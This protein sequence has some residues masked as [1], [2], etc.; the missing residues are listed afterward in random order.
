MNKKIHVKTGDTVVVLEGRDRGKKGKVLAVS[1]KEGKIIVEKIN[2]VSK[3]VKPRKAGQEGGIVKAEGALYASK[4]QLVCPHC[5]KPTRVGHK[6][7]G[8]GT[9]ERICKKCG[10]AL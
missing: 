1:P 4:V 8:D 9:K 6:I 5:G 10:E 2:M 3:H 7:Y